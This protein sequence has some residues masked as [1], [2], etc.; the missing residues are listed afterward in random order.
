MNNAKEVKLLG[1]KIDLAVSMVSILWREVQVLEGKVE[2]VLQ[3]VNQGFRGINITQTALKTQLRCSDLKFML[4]SFKYRNWP[5][6]E[7][8]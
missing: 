7:I 2:M 4:N 1:E 5:Q 3:G 8:N 6:K